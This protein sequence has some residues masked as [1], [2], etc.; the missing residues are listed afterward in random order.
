[1]LGNPAVVDAATLRD[2][3]TLRPVR[4]EIICLDTVDEG[5]VTGVP[6]PVERFHKMLFI[7]EPSRW[8]RLAQR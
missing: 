7:V 5:E 8:S 4:Q 1:M 2:F 3:R 6:N